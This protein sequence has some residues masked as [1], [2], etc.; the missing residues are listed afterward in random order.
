MPFVGLACECL[1]SRSHTYRR[2]VPLLSL[3][4]LPINL[5]ELGKIDVYTKGTFDGF[6]VRR[7]PV[8]RKLNPARKPFGHVRHKLVSVLSIPTAYQPRDNQFA[9]CIECCPRPYVA[10]TLRGVLCLRNIPSL[11]ITKALNLTTLDPLGGH[12]ADGR[13]MVGSTSH[14]CFCEQFGYG[15]EGNIN[16]TAIG[17]HGRPLAEP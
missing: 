17:P 11:G 2:A 9:V 3:R 7:V 16:H 15:I 6:Q 13:L 8:S 1:L 12:I 14:T 5:D 10:G 4:S